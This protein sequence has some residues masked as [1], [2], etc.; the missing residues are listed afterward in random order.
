RCGSATAAA[1]QVGKSVRGAY[2]L[3]ERAGAES[4][5]AAWHMAVAIGIDA[6][7]DCVIDR[8]MH[9]GWVP[10]VRRGRIVRMEFRQFDR[11]AIAILSGRGK[12]IEEQRAEAAR[13]RAYRKSLREEDLRRAAVRKAAAEAEAR[14]AE[15]RKKPRVREFRITT[16]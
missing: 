7:R 13:V 9:G 1:R 15:E 2:A 12:D 16:F 4:F 6:T 5:A 11:M 14:A 3:R 8:A 10:V